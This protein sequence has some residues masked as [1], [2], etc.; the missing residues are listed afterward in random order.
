MIVCEVLPATVFC[1][2]KWRFLVADTISRPC[3][4]TRTIYDHARNLQEREEAKQVFKGSKGEALAKEIGQKSA[5]EKV[6]TFTPG[7]PAKVSLSVGTAA[8]LIRTIRSPR[9]AS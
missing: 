8:A 3:R 9:I 6:K 1:L 4:G 2:T 7:E 5:P